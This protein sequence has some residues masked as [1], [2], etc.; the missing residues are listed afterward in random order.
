MNASSWNYPDLLSRPATSSLL[1]LASLFPYIYKTF[2]P[3]FLKF[4]G[5]MLPWPKLN[6]LLDLAETLN[7]EARRVYETKKKLL[8]SGDDE[9]VKQVG[10]GKDILS[11]LSTYDTVAFWLMALTWIFVVRASAAE[12]EADR[13]SED[14]LIGQMAYVSV[15]S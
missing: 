5:R 6:H 9:T 15:C 11:I 14:E 1:F 12:S 4:V 2:N 13:L 3:K 7:A 8:E 10:E